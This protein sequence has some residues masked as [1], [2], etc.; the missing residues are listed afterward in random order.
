M[1]CNIVLCILLS[2]GH[3]AASSPAKPSISATNAKESAQ[4][5]AKSGEQA[6]RVETIKTALP[7]VPK[8]LVNIIGEYAEPIDPVIEAVLAEYKRLQ[9]TLRY[10]YTVVRYT[11]PSSAMLTKAFAQGSS[12][13]L[14][15]QILKEIVQNHIFQFYKI[16][17]EVN[18]K[19]HKLQTKYADR[20]AEYEQFIKEQGIIVPYG[21]TALRK[22]KK[23]GFDQKSRIFQL[24][25]MQ[26]SSCQA[27]IR[28]P[29]PWMEPQYYHREGC[30][31]LAKLQ[32]ET[33]LYHVEPY[34][35]TAPESTE[36]NVKY[37]VLH[38]D[39]ASTFFVSVWPT[40]WNMVTVL[41]EF[42]AFADYVFRCEASHQKPAEAFS[43]IRNNLRAFYKP[44]ETF[45]WFHLPHYRENGINELSDLKH[46]IFMGLLPIAP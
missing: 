36:E 6:Q 20:W 45:R 37:T 12:I 28:Y 22:W 31:K 40:A 27:L 29:F 17:D 18:S 25:Q 15:D 43:M 35:K 10:L 39:R 41:P 26:C 13:N 42:I 34:G 33:G 21:N 1:S 8:E 32:K 46:M 24:S 9:E 23:G 38:L 3:C 30:S 11:R 4:E 19:F 2:T 44:L 7:A 16:S 5:K 14:L